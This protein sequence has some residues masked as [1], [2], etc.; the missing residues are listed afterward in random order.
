MN[1]IHVIGAGLAGS[2]A[3]I[4]ARGAGA[5]VVL[6]EKSRFPRH[7]VCGEFLSPEIMPLLEALGV[8]GRF[9]EASPA[10]IRRMCIRFGSREKSAVL[11]EAAYG[12][13]RWVLD[14]MLFDRAVEVGSRVEA[15]AGVAGTRTIV[16]HGRRTS[17]PKGARL[18]GFKA[19]FRGPAQDAIELHFFGSGYVGI[20]GI[21][22]G[23]TNVC[24]LATEASLARIGF[25]YDELLGSVPSIAERVRPL[26]RAMDWLTTGPL[27]YANRFD[28]PAEA[29]VY[30]AGDALSFVDPFTGSG[31][32]CAVLSGTIAGQSA[33][34]GLAA[35]EH[36]RRCREALGRPFAFASLL[37]GAIVSG[38]AERVA[39]FVPARW[40]YHLTRPR[41]G[42]SGK[43]QVAGGK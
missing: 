10:R 6:F 22:G 38:W 12:L 32:Y 8:G 14:E 28:D 41:A 29:G 3:A 15:V 27:V 9:M 36:V 16:A 11:P 13:S 23:L 17:G 31:M 1:A 34:Q 18:F 26:E 24:G 21:E 42:F 40:L 5:D 33:A 25:A 7:K 43:G 30:Y 20:S 35:A 37:R 19:H 4:T 39:P 2:A